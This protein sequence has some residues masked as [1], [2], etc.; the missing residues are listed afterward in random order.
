[1]YRLELAAAGRVVRS[2]CSSSS[3]GPR[4]GRHSRS[5][6]TA[7]TV[8]RENCIQPRACETALQ[9]RS[10][11]E[12]SPNR[13]SLAIGHGMARSAMDFISRGKR[14]LRSPIRTADPTAAMRVA[15]LYL[16][17]WHRRSRQRAISTRVTA[18]SRRCHGTQPMR[19][20]VSLQIGRSQP[21][22][23]RPASLHRSIFLT[24]RLLCG[25]FSFITKQQRGGESMKIKVNVR[26]GGLKGIRS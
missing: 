8:C 18:R 12:D 19:A 23:I 13:P 4:A 26:A 14:Y 22:E 17:A 24:S 21:T 11:A 9:P 16:A 1:V 3:T 20:S 6:S 2:I 10:A 5:T 7:S 25:S 15:S